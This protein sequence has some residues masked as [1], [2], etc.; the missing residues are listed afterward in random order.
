M[1][2][3][4]RFLTRL[5]AADPGM[6]RFRAAVQVIVA[7]V[8]AVGVTLPV[9]TALH[10]PLVAVAPAAVVGMVSM[11]AVRSRGRE[12][13]I[14]TLLLPVAATVSFTLAALVHGS[15]RI[16]ELVFL[17]VMFG[18]VWM[19][20]F[21]PRWF[22]AGMAAFIGY[23]LALFLQASFATL[24]AMAA[25]AFVGAGAALLARFVL[26]PERPE[27]AWQS[28]VRALRARVHTLL[29]AVDALGEESASTAKRRRVHDELLRLN[30]TALSLGTTFTALDALPAERA[31][32]LRRHVLDVELAAG[33]LVT[34]VDG[35][36]DEPVD[37][38]RHGGASA[39]RGRR[40]PRYG[41]PGDAARHRRTGRAS[42]GRRRTGAAGR[43]PDEPEETRRLLPT[44]RTAVQVVVA[45][46]LSIYIGGLVAPGQWF[47]R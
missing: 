36:I 23:F 30:A 40:R 42:R 11:L 9:L 14:T 4:R 15:I 6:R 10:Q 19:R 34:A 12:G 24:P 37:L 8:L 27:K 28:G 32:E 26:L 17:V 43:R 35:L 33:G 44:T 13:V 20:R 41:H 1:G 5:V 7:V 31:D 38:D 16:A 2:W 22:A 29:H 47:W 18:A 3:W 45:G 46:A 21:G 25:A 39:G